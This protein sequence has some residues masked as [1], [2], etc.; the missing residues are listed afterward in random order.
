[1][2]RTRHGVIAAALATLAM[3]ASPAHADTPVGPINPGFERGLEGW[4]RTG[5]AFD[6]QPTYQE[7]VM[8]S[9]IRPVRLGG[10]YWT[11]VPV[12]IG[13]RGDP[14]SGPTSIA[15]TAA[16]G[17]TQ[18]DEAADRVRARAHIRSRRMIRNEIADESLAGGRAR[19]NCQ[20]DADC[21][22]SR[23]GAGR[24]P[25]AA[26]CAL[27]GSRGPTPRDRRRGGQC[28]EAA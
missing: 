11:D 6:A 4:T 13:V 7:N 9:R 14:G 19:L 5:T 27:A 2:A 10:T 28:H 21:V 8:G 1:M 20:Y 23:P 24:D 3:A 22:R 12:P 15:P 25:Q 18:G 16:R 26:A 17:Q